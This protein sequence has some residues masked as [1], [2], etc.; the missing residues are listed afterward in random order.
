M[1]TLS[2]RALIGG[3]AATAVVAGAPAPANALEESTSYHL[4]TMSAAATG[5]ANAAAFEADVATA[6]G[7]QIVVPPAD[8]P[9]VVGAVD[10]TGATINVRFMPG[11]RL[12]PDPSLHAVGGKMFQATNC[13]TRLYGLVVDGQNKPEVCWRS[14]GGQF[15]AYDTT[16]SNFGFLDLAGTASSLGTLGILCKTVDEVIIDGYTGA[17]FVGRKNGTYADLAGKV[18][19]I[20]VYECER[21]A[22]RNVTI[23][24]GE[25]EDNDFLHILDLRTTPRM[26]G[27]I[28]SC[29]L[30]Y[31]GQTRRCLKFQGGN[32]DVRDIHCIP[33]PDFVSV[34]PALTDV[35][36]QNLNCIDWAGS[37][38]GELRLTDSFV[39]ATGFVV[40]VSH[41]IG[42]LGKVIVENCRIVGGRRHAIRTNPEPPHD[43]QDIQ[44]MGFF[45]ATT[46]NESEIRNSTI[47]GFSRAVVVQGNRVRVTGNVIDD[48]QDLWFQGGFS[49]ARDFLDLSGNKVYTRTAGAMSA[50]RCSRIDNY[51]NVECHNNTLIRAGNTTHAPVFIDVTNGAA[52]GFASNNRAPYTGVTSFRGGASA[53]VVTVNQGQLLRPL[54]A[55]SNV[56][57]VTTGEDNLQTAL[58]PALNLNAAGAAVRTSFTGTTASNANAKTLRVYL[59]ATL[60]MTKALTPNQSGA[61]EVQIVLISLG[62]NSQKYTV[63]FLE[64]DTTGSAAPSQAGIAV[65]TLAEASSASITLK[66]TGEAVANNDIVGQLA[67]SESLEGRH[68]VFTG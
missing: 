11:A 57:N 30:Y 7:K 64:C 42:P 22:I 14:D 33:G 13:N 41:T 36:E 52:S 29:H 40:G 35:G 50:S 12:V 20:M 19:H 4:S 31:N 56:G 21:V 6:A 10:I 66:T 45:A 34:N 68:F 46:E 49:T 32:W 26:H 51:S 65:G 27:T 28:S 60:V 16:M 17:D 25:G 59:G 15:R 39:D 1:S 48:P 24:G 38:D 23:S 9:Y 53:I 47:K 55:T 58:I 63:R 44:T 54:F 5:A 43:A 62:T 8:T 3:A 18:N 67:V 61:W 2:R 37:I